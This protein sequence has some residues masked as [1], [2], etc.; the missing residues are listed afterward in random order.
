MKLS[1]VIGGNTC[2]DI[3]SNKNNMDVKTA[4]Q[5]AE[6]KLEQRI[7]EESSEVKKRKCTPIEYLL[8]FGKVPRLDQVQVLSFE[9]L[10]V[11]D[12]KQLLVAGCSKNHLLKL[13]GIKHPGGPHYQ[14]LAELL[15]EKPKK[16]TVYDFTWITPTITKPRITINQQN[17]IRINA[18]AVKMAPQ[19]YHAECKARIGIDKVQNVLAIQPV[20]KNGY[21]FKKEKRGEALWLASKQVVKFLKESGLPLPSEFDT[22]WDSKMQAWV[23]RLVEGERNVC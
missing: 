12:A 22:S 7:K 1:N 13:Y 20:E 5:Q 19:Q 9:D 4:R 10:T 11:E 15:G 6:E 3:I 2:S 18:L 17:V 8:L 23:G 14:Q 16:Q 21:L